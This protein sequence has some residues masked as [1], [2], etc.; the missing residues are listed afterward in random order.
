MLP[1][2]ERYMR[3]TE[4]WGG[5]GIKSAHQ[6]RATLYFICRTL[7]FC[8]YTAEKVNSA[9]LVWRSPTRTRGHPRYRGNISC[10]GFNIMTPKLCAEMCDHTSGFPRYSNIAVQ[11]GRCYCGHGPPSHLDGQLDESYC[12]M[13]CHG[14]H[15]INCGGYGPPPSGGHVDTDP[16]SWYR[17]PYEP[18]T[19]DYHSTTIT[20]VRDDGMYLVELLDGSTLWSALGR[21]A[22]VEDVV[23]GTPPMPGKLVPGQLILVQRPGWWHQHTILRCSPT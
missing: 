4:T 14:D 17:L 11:V 9:I 8:I 19:A 23:P 22:T 12:I 6:S 1:S 5:D 7:Q 2:F 18:P 20:A 15:T 13:E 3:W 16:I 21:G 10:P